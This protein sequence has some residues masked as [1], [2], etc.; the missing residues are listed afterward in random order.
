MGYFT[1]ISAALD[2][3][4]NAFGKTTAWQNKNFKPKTG[5]TYL[6][7]ELL[8]ADSVNLTIEGLSAIE[9]LGVY[10]V[11]IVAPI[12]KGKSEGLTLADGLASHYSNVT[13]DYNGVKAVIKSISIG[14]ARRDDS[15]YITPIFIEYRAITPAR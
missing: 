4:L 11:D 2:S 3:R 6:K 15:W 9:H 13:V 8:P 1:D 12:N 10:Q 7:P 5:Q 14:T